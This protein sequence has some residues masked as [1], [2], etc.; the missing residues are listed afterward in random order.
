METKNSVLEGFLETLDE[1]SPEELDQVEKRLVSAR[2]KKNGNALIS[3]SPQAPRD[4]FAISFSDYL[5]MSKEERDELQ[6]AAYRKYAKW[7]E[8]ELGRHDARWILVCGGQVVESGPT[9][10][11]YPRA[12]RVRM[13]GEQYGLM[14]YVFVRGPVIEELN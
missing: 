13:V 8:Q 5:A 2:D 9:L 4:I 6:I 11:N 10:R 3:P 12:Q 7:I 1:L 14:P